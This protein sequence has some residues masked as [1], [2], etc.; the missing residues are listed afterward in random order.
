MIL[1]GSTAIKHWF[2]DFRR[3]PNDV[4]YIVSDYREN[5]NGVEYHINGILKDYPE[6]IL[7]ANDLLT[8]K[9]SHLF[10]D[11]RWDKHMFDAQFMIKKGC[12][13][14]RVLFDQLYTYWQTIHGPNKRSDLAIR[15]D[16]FF[17]NAL[18]K[19]DHDYLHTLLNP[20]PTYTKVLK[21][22]AEV[23][24]DEV[25]FQAL[26]HD[27]KLALLR[28]EV[29]VMAYE[30]LA[31]R[32]YTAAY[33]WMLKK[34]IMNHAP[35]WEALWII[36]NFIE[37]HRPHFNYKQKLDYELSRNQSGVENSL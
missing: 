20:I 18:K 34:F 31:G 30:R 12:T 4:D 19:Y 5:E 3:V 27:D 15:A 14:D 22:G 8:L 36:E 28:E 10:W 7:S 32:T 35:I 29:Y 2:P 26:S 23:E 37:L 13:I 17:N 25:K 33:T 9:V 6:D 1:I 11:I 21:D 16:D 24:P